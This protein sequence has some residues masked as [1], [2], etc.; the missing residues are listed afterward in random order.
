L[1]SKF[2]VIPLSY[3]L[4][5]IGAPTNFITASQHA[6]AREKMLYWLRVALLKRTF[7]GPTD[8]TLRAIR[9][10][11]QSIKQGESFP[12]EG[13]LDE[14]K[15]TP[16][17]MR[18]DEPE[19]DGVL[20]Y[21]YG[22]S[23]TFTVLSFLYPWLK[24]DQQF[25][26]D[27]VFPKSLF[28]PRE[29][30]K[31]GIPEENWH[32]WLEQVNGLGNLQLLQGAANQSKSDQEFESWIKGECPSPADLCSYR[33]LHMIPDVDLS[34]ENFP[35]FYEARVKLMREKLAELLNVQL[36]NNG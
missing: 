19:L 4:Y 31:R 8:N 30:R 24:Y 17:S 26:L 13:I 12:L 32:L 11:M 9:R 14:L 34:F 36:M 10:A 21:R 16:K 25:H 28:T 29:L 2:A 5:H 20:S 18:F 33:E 3:Y 23:Y 15:T 22:Q 6:Q 27:H 7:S 1:I 35:E